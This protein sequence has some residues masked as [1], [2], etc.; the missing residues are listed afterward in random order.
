[1]RLLFDQ[2]LSFR[3]A[4]SLADVY[5]GSSHVRNLRLDEADDND[6]WRYAAEN[7]FIIV[8]KDS[9]FHQMSLLYG[10][11]P[12]MVWLRVGNGPTSTIAELLRIHHSTIQRFD[13][14]TDSSLLT[15]A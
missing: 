10:H 4:D 9:D 11:P 1:M 2:N 6:I 5:P 3:L 12:K 8:S 7:G 14:D 15:L 13:G